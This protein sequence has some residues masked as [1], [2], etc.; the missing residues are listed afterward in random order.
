MA[1]QRL[2]AVLRAAQYLS[3]LSPEQD[4]WAELAHLMNSFF[5]CDF[6]LVVTADERGEPQLVRSLLAQTLPVAEIFDQ[7]IDEIRAVLASGFLGSQ[8]LAAPA[9][10]I[11]LLPLPGDRRTASVAIIGRAC[12]QAFS[13]EELEILLALGGLFVNVVARVE[14]ENGLREHRH[15]LE[16]LVAQRTAELTSTAARLA[17]E[18]M[19]RRRAE[20]ALGLA[21]AELEQIF[22][23]AADGLWVLD[24]SGKIR[25][26]NATHA[27]RLGRPPS[28]LVGRAC[29]EVSP[30]CDCESQRCPLTRIVEGAARV[31][32]EASRG[33]W[34][35]LVISTPFRAKDGTLVGI[36]Q[37]FHDMTERKRHQREL[38]RAKEAAE[39]ANRAKGDFLANMS[40]EIRTPMNGVIGMAGL[41][42]DTDLASDQR[43][44]AETI[45]SSGESLL[46]LLNDI[47]DFSKIEAGKL[48]LETIDF[49]LQALFADFGR[50]MSAPAVQKELELICALAP[51][52]P[53]LLRGDPGRLKQVLVNLTNNA[54]KFT[55]QGEVSVR[56]S[57]VRETD[58]E[59]LL[60][61][62]VRDTGVGIPMDRQSMLFQKFTQLDASTSR[63]YGG[64]GLGLAISKQLAELMG[65]EIGMH[66]DVGHGSEFWFTAKF[67]K[68]QPDTAM[69]RRLPASVSGVRALVLDANA[70]SRE[71][72]VTLLKAWGMRPAESADGKAVVRLLDEAL[73]ARD[74]FRAV[75]ADTKMPGMDGDELGRVVAGE[76]RF[77]GTN[78]V[79][80]VSLDRQG[81]GRRLMQAGFAGYLLKPVGQSDLGDCLAQVIGEES[82]Q[83]R[84]QPGSSPSSRSLPLRSSARILLAEDNI[85]NQQIALAM[86]SKLGLR[87]DVVAS[88]QEALDSL[89]RTRY[90]IVLMDIQMPEMDG[91]E[92]TRVA[93]SASGG[94][95]D[96]Y[97]PIIAMTANAMQGD[98]EACLSVGMDDYISKP[99]THAALS[100]LLD[101]WLNRQVNVS[102]ADQA[103]PAANVSASS[104]TG[105][106]AFIEDASQAFDEDELL[107]R[108]AGD[109]DL[110]KAILGVFLA[111]IP[112]QIA[113]L[114]GFLDGRDV[115][116]AGQQAHTIKGAAAGVSGVALTNVA[117][118]LEKA[119]K[120]GELESARSMLGQLQIEF[121]RLKTILEASKLFADS[122]S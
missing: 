25:K 8:I 11:A 110:A 40:H 41:L 46:M 109:R 66:S 16:E 92:A 80:M 17:Q 106:S 78:L 1:P 103:R 100:R 55:S 112:K 63:R 122:K 91:M 30:C 19:E 32:Y 28:E 84:K 31:E 93:R 24:R 79:A 117:F 116:A 57:L 67:G 99:V 59:V 102:S 74:P 81:D 42:L 113:R 86:L 104:R 27:R 38:G 70:T 69:P 120:A 97:V 62:S 94:I 121:E 2:T 5:G 13:K 9:C 76:T 54:V 75:L 72:L 96:R 90:D 64:T 34:D 95:L 98:R 7:A 68:Q 35:D 47:L 39:A 12:Q 82:G 118:A 65:G 14:T 85:T 58:G 26:V 6:L 115:G 18:S 21:H 49:D 29:H 107:D 45:R 119:G 83:G 111:D 20:V 37:V 101:K 4:I 3:N 71:V 114:K 36:V 77:A 10:S 73:A 56:A 61:F 87:A 108:L 60:R 51:D 23:T 44:F 89:R 53:V 105:G 43:Q 22:E 15:N 52:L 50:V 88:G 48:S 33:D